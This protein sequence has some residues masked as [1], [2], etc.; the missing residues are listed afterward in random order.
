L[1]RY[2]DTLKRIV[3]LLCVLMMCLSSAPSD[4]IAADFDVTSSDTQAVTED[5]LGDV[6]LPVGGLSPAIGIDEGYN[7]SE[8]EV[9]QSRTNYSSVADENRAYWDKFTDK[10]YYNSLNEYQKAWWDSMEEACYAALIGTNTMNTI[11][12]NISGYSYNEVASMAGNLAPMFV[13]AHPQYYFLSNSYGYG[14]YGDIYVYISVYSDF[15]DGTVRQTAT[16]SFK[17]KVDAYLASINTET[18]LP[19]EI[20]NNIV[21]QLREKVTY[22]SNSMDQTAYST[23]VLGQT[24]CAGYTKATTLL[25]NACGVPTTSVQGTAGGSTGWGNH[26]WNMVNLHGNWYY[27]DSTWMDQ[28]YGLYYSYYNRSLSQFSNDHASDTFYANLVPEAKYDA[29]TATWDHQ[30]AYFDKDNVKYFIVNRNTNVS[31]GYLV[32]AVK[33]LSSSATVPSTVTYS[34]V[35]YK[36]INADEM[37]KVDVHVS[38]TTHVQDVGWQDP[39]SDGKVAGTS[40]RGLRLEGIKINVTGDSNLEVAYTTHVQEYGWLSNSYD[41]AMSGTSGESKRLEAIMIQLQGTDA[42]KYDI[43]YRVHAQEFGWLGWAKNG[44]PAGTAGYGYRLEAIQIVITK[45][46]AAAPTDVEGITSGRSNAYAAAKSSETPS[47]K[48]YGDYSISYTTHVQEIGWQDYVRNGAMAGTSGKSLRLE[49]IKIKFV[50]PNTDGAISYRTHVQ[51][52]GWMDYVSNDTMSGTSGESKRL[53]AIEIKLTGTI[54]EQYD[55][56]YRVHAQDVGWMGWAK[57]GEQ[58]GTSGFGRRLEGIQIILVKKGESAPATVEGITSV[59]SDAFLDASAST[60][61]CTDHEWVIDTTNMTDITGTGS[62]LY[63]VMRCNYCGYTDTTENYM[64][65]KHY[66]QH[67]NDTLPAQ[68]NSETT[69]YKGDVVYKCS[70]C[71]VAK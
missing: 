70:K 36:V 25:L 44:A 4:V 57:N 2:K 37:N 64:K 6:V 24:V 50:N 69:K 49:G 14:Q 20:E 7:D 31:E 46:G 18:M 16:A 39:V 8:S 40:G 11:S 19:E 65:S 29:S 1:K 71:G 66:T 55:V 42:D 26:A 17:E 60:T 9:T 59:V 54:A 3:A 10:Y 52:Y 34:N 22:Q 51:D 62:S 27:L 41:G 32:T 12:C 45:K 47:M 15:Q 48:L 33:K 56:Y 58:A 30:V 5:V 68:Y 61:E 21:G 23:F 67:T 53:E 35:T 63:S 38:Y 13:Y 43:Y 28:N